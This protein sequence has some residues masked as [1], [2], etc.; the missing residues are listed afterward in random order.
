M[1][2]FIAQI[3]STCCVSTFPSFPVNVPSSV[4]FFYSTRLHSSHVRKSLNLLVC[5]HYTHWI[6]GNAMRHASCRL[7]LHNSDSCA[8]KFGCAR[9]QR[10]VLPWHDDSERGGSERARLL[11][12]LGGPGSPR[13]AGLKNNH[14]S[15]SRWTV[16]S[17]PL[18]LYLENYKLPSTYRIF[19]VVM[20]GLSVWGQLYPKNIGINVCHQQMTH[21]WKNCSGRIAAIVEGYCRCLQATR[22]FVT[23]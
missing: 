2:V 13:E 5:S 1:W 22:H 15:S 3:A 8:P 4:L 16:A 14:L 7:F 10:C 20:R 19:E 18:H 11:C 12:A 6:H 9:A 23:V 21:W 17:L